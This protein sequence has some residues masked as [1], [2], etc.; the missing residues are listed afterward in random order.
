MSTLFHAYFHFL[1]SLTASAFPCCCSIN[2]IKS[3]VRYFTNYALMPRSNG[4]L[5]YFVRILWQL[6]WYN[7]FSYALDALV[8][9]ER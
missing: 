7:S 3:G 8:L 2:H 6:L 1:S 9:K 5:A 4:T